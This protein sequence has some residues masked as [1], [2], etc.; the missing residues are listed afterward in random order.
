MWPNAV[1]HSVADCANCLYTKLKKLAARQISFFLLLFSLNVNQ[2]KKNKIPQTLIKA[3]CA[4][5]ARVA[6]AAGVD[7]AAVVAGQKKV[8]S[9]RKF[10]T[11]AFSHTHLTDAIST[12]AHADTKIQNV[13]FYWRCARFQRLH[14]PT[15]QDQNQT[16]LSAKKIYRNIYKKIVNCPHGNCQP[17]ASPSPTQPPSHARKS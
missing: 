13:Y 12:N 2:K 1:L 8:V 6:A 3:N 10:T 9:S 16:T 11:F 14:L 5:D 17:S 7:V 15:S 4:P